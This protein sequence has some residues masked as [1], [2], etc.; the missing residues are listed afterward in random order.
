MNNFKTFIGAT[1]LASVAT[2]NLASASEASEALI[3]AP[4]PSG[5]S[6]AVV[7]L[8]MRQNGLLTSISTYRSDDSVDSTLAFYRSI[9]TERKSDPGHVENVVGEWQIISRLNGDVNLVLQLKQDGRGGAQGL[10]SSVQL[11]DV[12]P[13]VSNIDLPPG[14]EVVSSIASSDAGRA[15]N[16]WVIRSTA[17]T[18]HAASYY[19]DVLDRKGW[20][21][22]SDRDAGGPRVLQFNRSGGTIELVISQVD[23]GSTL[24]VL[25]QVGNDV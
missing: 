7:G 20:K 15:A 13:V 18:G 2:M 17:G 4:L 12:L 14:G 8:D 23:D 10:F 9:W 11:N 1:I 22:V 3:N 5:A 25:N 24:S 21:L 16:T 19:R 6:M